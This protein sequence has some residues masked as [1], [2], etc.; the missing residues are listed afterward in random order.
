[1]YQKDKWFRCDWEGEAVKTFLTNICDKDGR[2]CKQVSELSTWSQIT[3]WGD[4]GAVCTKEGDDTLKCTTSLASLTPWNWT[5]KIKQG[6]VEKWSFNLNQSTGLTINLDTWSNITVLGTNGYLCTKQS[7]NSLKC[8]TD[9]A[10]LIPWNGKI[11]IK[12]WTNTWSFNLND[13]A[14]QTLTLATWG[15]G[16]SGYTLPA[17]TSTTLWG[18]K[19]GS[20][21]KQ[22][23]AANSVT[24]T[25]LR[26]YAVQVN[27]NGQMVVNVPREPWNGWSWDSLWEEWTNTAGRTFSYIKPK[28]SSNNLYLKSDIYYDSA[29]EFWWLKSDGS[30]RTRQLKLDSAWIRIWE[31]TTTYGY[32]WVGIWV[33]WAIWIWTFS[34]CDSNRLTMFATWN[35]DSWN[36]EILGNNRLLVGVKNNSYLFLNSDS[37]VGINTTGTVGSTLNVKWSVKVGNCGKTKRVA[38][39]YYAACD[40]TTVWQIRYVDRTDPWQFVWCIKSGTN[41]YRVSLSYGNNIVS[42]FKNSTDCTPAIPYNSDTYS[43]IWINLYQQCSL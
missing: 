36:F 27:S 33:L 5:I 2:N 23:T 13:S 24:S 4:T 21:T 35:I 14:D 30:N 1:M 31:S 39:Q 32:T 12:Q 43:S 16:G 7:D 34:N 20:D 38:N 10:N 25:A 17:A 28:T 3:I 11:T 40:E 8:S 41:Y 37:N 19:L 6:W 26:T 18:V 22:T 42:N 29:L 15:N 9:P